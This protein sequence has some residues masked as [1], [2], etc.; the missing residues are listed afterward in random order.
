[1]FLVETSTLRQRSRYGEKLDIRVGTCKGN[2]NLAQGLP[3]L[4]G[5]RLGC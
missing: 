3:V 2:Q 1:M 5:V 4:A